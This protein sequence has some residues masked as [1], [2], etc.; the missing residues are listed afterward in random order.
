[1]HSTAVAA[2]IPYRNALERYGLLHRPRKADDG[3]EEP[4][5]IDL[6]DN[7]H[8]LNRNWLHLKPVSSET[9][10]IFDLSDDIWFFDQH[11]LVDRVHDDSETDEAEEEGWELEVFG[12]GD[13]SQE[14]TEAVGALQQLFENIQIQ[15]DG[16]VVEEIDAESHGIDVDAV[17]TDDE[18]E[19]E[20]NGEEGE[21]I[22]DAEDED[23]VILTNEGV[24]TIEQFRTNSSALLCY[25][26][27]PAQDLVI[28]AEEWLRGKV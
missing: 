23:V 24:H 25:K 2:M 26:A 6:L 9:M 3:T 11:I 18:D 21:G 7:L 13:P 20:A 22:E 4:A 14:E 19:E 12:Y 8:T 5:L 1:M 10:K 27:D 15:A 28:I 16:T 17:E